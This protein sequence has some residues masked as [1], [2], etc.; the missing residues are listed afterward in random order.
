MSTT[1]DI[2]T[3]PQRVSITAIADACGVNRQDVQEWRARGWVPLDHHK[4]IAEALCR[5]DLV[6]KLRADLDA[7]LAHKAAKRA[8]AK[9]ARRAAKVAK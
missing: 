1:K 5:P 6:S 2:L 3:A 8:A 9:A 4:T 7:H